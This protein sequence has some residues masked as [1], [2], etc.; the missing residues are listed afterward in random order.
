MHRLAVLALA[1]C[2]LTAACGDNDNPTSPSNVPMVFSAI[3]SPANEVPPVTNAE[4]G[5][6]GA[7]QI[8]LHATRDAAGVVTGGTADMYFQMSGFPEG[9]TVVGAHIHAAPAGVNG[10]IVVSTGITSGFPFVAE[11]GAGEFRVT[12]ML[13][14]AATAQGL[15][16]NPEAF[17]FN[18]HSP[19][20]RG[21]FVRGQLTRIQ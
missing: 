14:D 5:G 1:A 21:G 9:T 10:P 17:Y 12:G 7:T 6:T 2:A 18:I 13:V 20:N 15:I 3:L 8:T 11:T 16:N 4:S 19:L